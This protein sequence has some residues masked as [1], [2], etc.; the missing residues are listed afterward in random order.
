MR[1]EVW[2]GC[3]VIGTLCFIFKRPLW[4][5]WCGAVLVMRGLKKQVGPMVDRKHGPLTT[6]PDRR[7]LDRVPESVRGMLRA[8]T[9]D[10]PCFAVDSGNVQILH[11]PDEFYRSI[12]KRLR[13]ATERIV[14]AALYLGVTE[15]CRSI[16]D[17]IDHAMSD[18]EQL[19]ATILVDYGR[20][21]RYENGVSVM[22]LLTPLVEK[23]GAHRVKVSMFMV[24]L[25][26]AIFRHAPATIRE[27]A[28]VQHVKGFVVDDDTLLTGANLND[29]YF[30]T[31]QDRYVWVRSQANLAK[32]TAQFVETLA[33]MS[34]ICRPSAGGD[35]VPTFPEG[36]SHPIFSGPSPSPVHEFSQDLSSK[37]L[38]LL[39]YRESSD[40]LGD[41]FVCPLTQLAAVGVWHESDN[42][43]LMV[44]AAPA[45]TLTLSSAYPNFHAS[46]MHA[47]H[48]SCCSDVQ[49][50]SPAEDANGFFGAK[51][52]KALVP[53]SYS[54]LLGDFADGMKR[55]V[56]IHL[57]SNPGC[58]YHVKGLWVPHMTLIGS[59]NY[60]YRSRYLDAELSFVI[61]TA[62]T[63]LADDFSHERDE[64]LRRATSK[65]SEELREHHTFIDSMFLKVITNVLY[66]F[67]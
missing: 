17:A 5:M 15:K 61:V 58:T 21:L 14:I 25:C 55:Q 42:L 12:L 63:A 24:P 48:D 18:N 50:L 47:L 1:A 32:W 28:G 52:P 56:S 23:Y 27:I 34:Y 59:S 39:Q 51:W 54:K 33:A 16:A 62:S 53:P 40:V 20:G 67:L 38:Q 37:V 8:V 3:A 22:T 26:G 9:S 29:D 36:M 41:T 46:L 60:G 13:S 19:T 11:T 65:S 6:Q 35:V 31:R 64:V 57:W 2:V 66:P 49:L 7:A 45:S 43:D 44:R 30:T 10:A 4:V